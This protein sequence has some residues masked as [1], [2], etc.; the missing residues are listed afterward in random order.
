MFQ[1]V[2]LIGYRASITMGFYFIAIGYY[3][4]LFAYFLIIRF[5]KTRR[6]YWLLFSIFFL[7]LALSGA[8]FIIHD[9]FISPLEF[10]TRALVWRIAS[11]F[12]WLAILCMVEILVILM[13]T[14]TQKWVRIVKIGLPLFYVLMAVLIFVL[15]ESLVCEGCPSTVE[16]QFLQNVFNYSYPEGRFWLNGII[17]PVTTILFPVLFF[18]LGYRSAGVIRCSSMLNGLGFLLYFV[19][20]LIEPMP[21]VANSEHLGIMLLPPSFILI[22]LLI[23]VIANQYE[24]LK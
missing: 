9:F 18:N 10:A 19:G 22:S 12:G 20:R 3:F 15:P 5:R 13:F 14:G 11:F 23:L 8:G 4:L 1:E 17:L 24:H 16:N 21:F 6:R 2:P 7:M